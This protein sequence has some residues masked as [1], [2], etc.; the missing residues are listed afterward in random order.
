MSCD[1]WVDRGALVG[2][3]C[4]HLAQLV[5]IL[6]RQLT[7]VGADHLLNLNSKVPVHLVVRGPVQ[8][9]HSSNHGHQNRIVVHPATV[10][11]PARWSRDSFT[12]LPI[13]WM[14]V[15]WYI[16]IAALVP[17]A[18]P[19]GRPSDPATARSAR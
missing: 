11:E 10:T 4:C 8:H 12:W 3:S 15:G 6:T 18:V 14:S 9:L 1:C 5:H 17:F 16:E 19:A 2:D 7:Q 13:E